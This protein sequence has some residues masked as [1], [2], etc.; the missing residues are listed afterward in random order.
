[1]IT[2][3]DVFL[4]EALDQ[5]ISEKIKNESHTRLYLSAV[6]ILKRMER[7]IETHE[8]EP[9]YLINRW[10]EFLKAYPVDLMVGLMKDMKNS[11]RAVYK[12]AIE[13][14]QFVEA[15]FETYGLIRG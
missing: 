8:Y 13:N 1:L 5:A 2:Y 4:G 10:I 7:E 15:Y 9:S 11:Y 6:N 14:E 3:E 12:S